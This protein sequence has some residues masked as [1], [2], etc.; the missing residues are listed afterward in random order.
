MASSSKPSAQQMNL[1]PDQIRLTRIAPN[2]KERF[3][4]MMTLPNLFGEWV[5]LREWGRIGSP[6]RVRLDVHRS[7]G[8]AINALTALAH[9]KRRRGYATQRAI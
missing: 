4:L 5:L 8:D 6:G 7:E 9:Q 1:F 2:N 3:Y